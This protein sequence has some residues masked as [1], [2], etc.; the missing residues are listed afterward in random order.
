MQLV[1]FL[2]LFDSLIWFTRSFMVIRLPR[3]I[4]DCCLVGSSWITMH[5]RTLWVVFW[6]QNCTIMVGN[7]G[8]DRN[9]NRYKPMRDGSYSFLWEQLLGPASSLALL[10]H[11]MSVPSVL[12][13]RVIR[14]CLVL[15]SVL[16][17]LGG[18]NTPLGCKTGSLPLSCSCPMMQREGKNW[19]SPDGSILL[20]PYLCHVEGMDKYNKASQSYA[21]HLRNY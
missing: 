12:L 18:N 11:M 15:S 16:C 1:V 2:W 9:W 10:E 7:S 13:S 14:P 5:K 3:G 17:S 4:L 20:L 21:T 19:I 8:T 6:L